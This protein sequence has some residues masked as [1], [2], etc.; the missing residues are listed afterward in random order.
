MLDL[1]YV[2]AAFPALDT[3][4]AHLDNAGGTAPASPV[5]ERIAAALG[6]GMVARGGPHASSAEAAALYADGHAALAEWIA[7]D[8]EEVILGA[9]T[10]ANLDLLARS[11][12]P[13]WRVGD[14]VI[15]TDLDHEAN[16]SPWRRLEATGI[17]VREWRLRPETARLEVDD[18]RPLLRARTRLVAF[19]HCANVVGAL[20]DVA[21]I[22]EVIHDAGALACVDGVAFA[23]HRPIDV[24][25]LGVDFYAL[26]LYKLFGPHLGALYGKRA[27]LLGGAP[28]AHPFID[29]TD[30]PYRYEPGGASPELVAGIPGIVDYFDALDHHSFAIRGDADEAP[31]GRLFAAIAEHEA[32]LTGRL[33]GALAGTRARVVGPPTAD[34]AARVALVAFAIP[35]VPSA[36]IAAALAD[37]G[38][39]ARSGHFYAPRAVARLDL[40]PRCGGLVR[41]S[42]AH[43]NTLEEIDRAVAALAPLLDP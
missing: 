19:T 18:L 21:A 22:T 15:V 40:D 26:S 37:A 7:A 10:T 16:I 2:R 9:S 27:L 4:W 35:G 33:L 1:D 36:T 12:R 43:Y 32:E 30:L 23:P 28:P 34:P 24:R 42:L 38:I 11:L 14:E 31:R 17:I 13:R 3:S 8:P 20:H 25:A 5:C 6:R 41:L 29:L 39:A